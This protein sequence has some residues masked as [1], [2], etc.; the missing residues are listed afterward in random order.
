VKS[1]LDTGEIDVVERKKN[2][3]LFN[4]TRQL[5]S[6]HILELLAFLYDQLENGKRVTVPKLREHLRSDNRVHKLCSIDVLPPCDI[7]DSVIRKTMEVCCHTTW[8]KTTA[9]GKKGGDMSSE[10]QERRKWRL[11][12][13]WAQYCLAKLEEEAGVA[14]VFS[15]DES[16]VHNNHHSDFS[17]LPT[18]K[19][20]KPLAEINAAKRSG[21]RICIA[22]GICKYGHLVGRN[23]N[24]DPVVDSDYRNAR[25][26]SV[27]HGGT[28]VELNNA[29]P[30]LPRA[31]YNHQT[32]RNPNRPQKK[33]KTPLPFEKMSKRDMCAYCEQH[34]TTIGPLPDW[35]KNGWTDACRKFLRTKLE[36]HPDL[37]VPQSE[38]VEVVLPESIIAPIT[39]TAK[40]D[41]DNLRTV[42]TAI[43]VTDSMSNDVRGQ[44]ACAQQSIFM[45]WESVRTSLLDMAH[46]AD[47]FFP[48]LQASGDYHKNFDSYTFFKW[49]V[50]VE[51]TYPDF[52]KYLQQLKNEGK[53]HPPSEHDFWDEDNQKPSRKMILF[54]DNA[55][56]H[57]SLQVQLSSKSK[58]DCALY[59]RGLGV[60][61]IQFTRHTNGDERVHNVEVPE[62]GQEWQKNYPSADELREVTLKIILEKKP[63]LIQPPYAMLM[64][65]K[66]NG[67]WGNGTEGWVTRKSAPYVPNEVSVE[68]KWADGKNFAALN[69]DGSGS[70]RD[71]I[72]MVR[73]RWYSNKTSC[74][75]LFRHAENEMLRAINEDYE[76]N[77]GPM[78]GQSILGIEGLPDEATLGLWM[79]KAGMNKD[80]DGTSYDTNDQ[81]F[82]AEEEDG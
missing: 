82:S 18:D 42:M 4:S 57:Q 43:G 5:S 35:P 12:V 46:T 49:M 70:A 76:E 73:G 52:C 77:E 26:D 13:W 51:L 53:L 1:Y 60:K 33:K 61:T 47:K 32:N 24:G 54:I 44:D 29:Y 62:D 69:S 39:E 15:A 28:F 27:P 17:L 8:A 20:R 38:N 59:L 58:K 25:G 72:N 14:L 45:D 50:A 65:S 11:R 9:V 80:Y 71:V 19:N 81:L 6:V 10:S 7:E 2:I 41:D 63:S 67:V 37:P 31:V 34:S 21:S 79:E 40:E 30:P 23:P 16:Y 48:A 36:E 3:P 74:D 64:E 22:G 55:P 75:S 66:K 68:L 56:Y 78:H